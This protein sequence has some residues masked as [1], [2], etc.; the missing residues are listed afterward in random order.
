MLDEYPKKFPKGTKVT[1]PARGDLFEHKPTK[2]L[3]KEQA[4][5]F[6]TAVAQGL[7]ICKRA[8]LDIQPVIA[9]LCT[10]VKS[11]TVH[12]QQSL[13]QLMKWL[14]CT[15]GRLQEDRYHSRHLCDQVE[16]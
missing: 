2:L 15:Q 9:V 3:P 12:D 1:N 14:Y 8:R 4:E 6:H 5:A 13:D 11:P 16:H 7:F 10:R